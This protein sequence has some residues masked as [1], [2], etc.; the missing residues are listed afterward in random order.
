[1]YE[2]LENTKAILNVMKSF[3]TADI[4]EFKIIEFVGVTIE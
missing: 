2:N 1:M 4:I 3:A